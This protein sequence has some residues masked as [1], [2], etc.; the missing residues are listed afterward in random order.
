MNAKQRLILE[1]ENSPDF[2]VREV[3]QSL[4]IAKAKYAREQARILLKSPDTQEENSD[5]YSK[6][7]WELFDEAVKNLPEEAISELPTDGAAQA[8]H[9]IYGTPKREE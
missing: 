9:Y 5:N 3:F 7:I 1:I 6:P 8:D 4:L 2:I